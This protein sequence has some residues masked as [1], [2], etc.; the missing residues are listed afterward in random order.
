MKYFVE[1]NGREREVVIEETEGAVLA[2]IGGK[3]RRVELL[4]VDGFGEYSLL[5]EGRSFAV[6][7]EEEGE[8]GE[9]LRVGLG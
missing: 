1:V 3:R 7:I 8:R 2:R 5:L 4:D 9:T 6:S